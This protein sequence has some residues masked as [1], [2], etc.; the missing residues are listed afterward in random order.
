MGMA[1]R[2]QL[3]RL[4]RILR[5]LKA[6]RY[7]DAAEM[8]QACDASRRTIYRDLATLADAGFQIH[9]SPEHEGYELITQAPA[10]QSVLLRDEVMAILVL[11]AGGGSGPPWPAPSLRARAEAGID[12]LLAALPE[13]SRAEVTALRTILRMPAMEHNRRTQDQPIYQTLLDS[14]LRQVQ[15]RISYLGFPGHPPVQ[16]RFQPYAVEN[17]AHGWIVEGRSTVDRGVIRIPIDAIEWIELTNEPLIRPPRYD[18]A[19]AERPESDHAPGI[20]GATRKRG[21][22]QDAQDPNWARNT[23]PT[24]EPPAHTGTEG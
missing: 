7:P 6:R 18:S 4:I 17:S 21:S 3:E 20:Q 5:I 11:I 19:C 16:T 14:I 13:S 23:D 15:V 10:E 9:Y 1:R 12:K 2:S 8:G 22:P 24:H